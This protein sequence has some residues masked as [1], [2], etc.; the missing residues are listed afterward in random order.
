MTALPGLIAALLRS[1]H[2]GRSHL[3]RSRGLEP[4]SGYILKTLIANGPMRLTTLADQA[5]VDASQVSRQS[6][7]LIERGYLERVP[8]PTDGRASLLQVTS[9]GH[10]F[11]EHNRELQD[12]F[13]KRVFADWQPADQAEFE[14]LLGRFI[15]DFN[16]EFTKLNSKP[17]T[18]RTDD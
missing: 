6:H 2:S 17:T 15:Q 8:D 3:A 13:F 14:R 18:E 11:H 5:C 16:Q 4:G 9:L 12:G 10:E 7:L 1:A